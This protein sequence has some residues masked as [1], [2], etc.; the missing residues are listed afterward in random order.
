MEISYFALFISVFYAIGFGLL[1]Y[2]LWSARRSTQAAAWPTAQA[3]ITTL[4][5][6][7]NSDSEGTTYKVEV[8]YSYTVDGV[9]YSGSRLAFGYG[10]GSERE[11]HEIYRM[12]KKDKTVAVRYNPSDPAVSCVLFGLHR[13]IRFLLAFAATWMLFLLGFTLLFFL[14]SRRD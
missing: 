8:Q 13:S 12:L 3:T 5:V 7:E 9:A 4:E 6:C 14:I 2:G 10:G 11:A 1:G